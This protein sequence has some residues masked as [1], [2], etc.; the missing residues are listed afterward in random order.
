MNSLLQQLYMI[1][2]FQNGILS[3]DFEKDENLC[4]LYDQDAER[5]EKKEKKKE[6]KDA[7]PRLKDLTVYQLQLMFSFL[8]ESQKKFYNPK[9][10]CGSFKDHSGNPI[11][12]S[13]QACVERGTSCSHDPLYCC[14]SLCDVIISSVLKV[15]FIKL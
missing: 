8:K 3:L 15:S 13:V 4:K 12:V 14:E 10:F 1:P 7:L 2:A 5:G 9:P 11:D 6:D